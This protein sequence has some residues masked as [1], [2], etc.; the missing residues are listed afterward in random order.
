[1]RILR[2]DFSNLRSEWKI[3]G[4]IFD[5]NSL[6]EKITILEKRTNEPG[7]WEDNQ[8]AQ[9]VTREIS[10]HRKLIEA[11]EHLT[12]EI[13]DTAELLEIVDEES[14]EAKEIEVSLDGLEK[15]VNDMETEAR[16][17]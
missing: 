6:R 15:R 11:H 16:L 7:F 10:R 3:S 17:Y 8:A 13:S 4:G 9:K 14:D 12:R 2:I 5:L 1:M